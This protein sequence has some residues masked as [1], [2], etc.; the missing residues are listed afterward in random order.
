M[1]LS[2]QILNLRRKFVGVKNEEDTQKWDNLCKH[3]LY[4]LAW[5]ASKEDRIIGQDLMTVWKSSRCAEEDLV[6]LTLGLLGEDR[7]RIENEECE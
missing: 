1:K 2:E 4:E 6:I 7:K 5:D 3:D